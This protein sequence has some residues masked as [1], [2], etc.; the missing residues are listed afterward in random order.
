[1]PLGSTTPG[2]QA[3]TAP[4]SPE[5]AAQIAL[6]SDRLSDA[7]MLMDESFRILYA[8]PK[9]LEISQITAEN[10][11]RETLWELY[12]GVL[13]SPL[14]QAYLE[15]VAT[16]EARVV[17][18]FYYEP[19]K[20]AFDLR[21]FP[22]DHGV[23]VHYRD[24]TD[25]RKAEAARDVATGRL[26]Q[27][28][29]AT[30]DGVTS[31][32]R[33]W[34]ITYM[35]YRSK[36]ILA[37]SG[38][39]LGKNVWEC[40]PHAVYEGSPYVEH[41]YRAMDER[42][43][44]SFVAYYPEP[45][46]AWL[47]I[48]VRPSRDGMIAFFRDV[49]AQK[50]KEDALRESEERYRILTELNPQ[51]LWTAD[52]EGRVLYANQR[53]LEYIGHDFVPRDGD[54]YLRCFDAADRERV[55]QAWSHSI[56]TG[57]DYAIDA[58]LIRAG[59]GASRWWHLRALPI[60]D[61][62]G[63]ILQW[64]GVA[65]DVHESREA[66]DRLREQFIEIDRQRREVE[67]IYLG[68]PIGM[69]LYDAKD[70]RLLRINARQAEIFRLTPQEAMGK[71]YDELAGG[72]PEAFELIQRAAAGEAV[73]NHQ[74]EGSLD[75][76]P[77]EY[78]YWNINYSP[79]FAEDGSV[80]AIA[81]ATYELTHQKR[82][83]SALI[84]SEKL[85]AV[86][87]LASSI[88]HEI[89]NPLESVMNL[90]YI[91][92]QQATTPEIQTFLDLADQELRRVSVIANQTLRF[93]KQATRP[94]TIGCAD[95]FSTVLSIYEGRLKN[96]KITVEK[97]KRAE[98]PILCFEGEIRQVLNNLVSNAIDAMSKGGRL[99]VRSRE[100][101]DWR[102]GV[103]GL[104]LTVADTGA[105]MDAETQTRIFEAFFT[106]KGLQG[107]GLG[108]WISA[109]IIERHHGRLR[110]RSS[111]GT[112]HGTVFTVFLPFEGVPE[113]DPMVVV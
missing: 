11:N 18:N 86:G 30:T 104:V 43:P 76:R 26:E 89:N 19:L 102:S 6:L 105:G 98:R 1:M 33:D 54:E 42:I 29:D 97:R 67:T 5:R 9:A 82:A 78:R 108:L 14:G 99:L 53:F 24:V 62:N 112:A 16:R 65:N 31:F 52:P 28:L 49:T 96:S 2:S 75:R 15:A 106:T 90:I 100:A 20:T 44:G 70:L 47:H 39:I 95:L 68:S 17:Q 8:N 46:N 48:S 37:P 59:D 23:G 21:I 32:D 4:V 60:R 40:F 35:N 107:T 109:E 63:T 61:E 72:V 55:V 113:A 77:D 91:A 85:A 93:H 79:I 87:R 25:V 22:M 71:T 92:R 3:T 103:R 45:L 111:Q 51:S 69:A 73:L 56:A 94:Q 34:R 38:D 58:R 36:E 41:Y 13:E 101:T 80:R 74:L 66:E 27:V 83:E 64:L 7:I 50:L 84:Q 12:P 110:V 88:A 81:S 10:F 57:E